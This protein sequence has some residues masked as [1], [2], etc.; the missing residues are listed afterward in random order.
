MNTRYPTARSQV[1]RTPPAHQLSDWASPASDRLSPH[2]PI[3]HVRPP[4][5]PGATTV[6]VRE[7]E[8][9]KIVPGS[10]LAL[11]VSA[12]NVDW[13]TCSEAVRN[14]RR[15]LP[16]VPVVLSLGP[17]IEDGLFLAGQ[18]AKASV[19]AVVAGNAPLGESLRR[20]L[21]TTTSIGIDVV[22]WL[23]LFGLRLSP[24]L[25]HL[26]AQIFTA[27][28]RFTEVGPLL[29]SIGA[30]ESSTRFRFRKKSL[31][32]PSRWLQAARALHA[33][34]RIQI[35]PGRSILSH[36]CALG[37][38]DHSA[39]CHQM[40]RIFGTTPAAVRETLGWE[41]LLERWVRSEVLRAHPGA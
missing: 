22:E 10:V 23:P 8:L 26:I 17:D 9:S 40:K 19:R 28:P 41:W 15:R 37:Y 39:L 27:A 18:A 35:D 31:P 33:A 4:Y 11:H 16:A 32:A 20:P 30:A 24:T 29:K 7:V 1:G 21:T 6:M 34:M 13:P 25:N 12:R 36:A 2:Y 5:T 38:A 14:L 3:L